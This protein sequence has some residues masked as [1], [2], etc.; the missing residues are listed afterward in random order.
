MKPLLAILALSLP[1]CSTIS[2]ATIDDCVIG[3]GQIVSAPFVLAADAA[4]KKPTQPK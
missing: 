2:N 1:S 4:K 3:I